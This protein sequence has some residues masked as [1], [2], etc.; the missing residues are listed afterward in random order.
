M[1]L[2]AFVCDFCRQLRRKALRA[3]ANDV[4]CSGSTNGA[5]SLANRLIYAE[6][7]GS[8][9]EGQFLGAGFQ[10]ILNAN[11]GTKRTK[12]QMHES[13]SAAEIFW[14]ICASVASVSPAH[15]TRFPNRL[16]AF[17]RSYCS[18]ETIAIHRAARQESPPITGAHRKPTFKILLIFAIL[19]PVTNENGQRKC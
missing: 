17:A 15:T 12:R 6:G 16:L 4:R 19:G 7:Q 2:P 11:P 5:M 3:L 18:R 8:A 14:H 9:F 1:S 10:P 13:A